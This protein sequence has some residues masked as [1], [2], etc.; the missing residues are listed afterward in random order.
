M[1]WFSPS[2]RNTA[3][4]SRR[5]TGRD[6]RLL[7]VGPLPPPVHGQSAVMT[8][9]VSALSPSFPR[10]RLV[11]TCDSGADKWLGA[12][13]TVQ[14]SA[15]SW[16]LALRS[17]AVYVAVKAG[18][19]MWLTTITAAFARMSGARLLLHHHSYEYVRARRT[20]MVVLAR[21]AGPD[22][23]HIV[24]SRKMALDLRRV[25]PETGRTVVLG[26]AG[27]ID[28]GLLEVPL[29]IPATPLTLGH[30]SNLSV[31]KGIVEVVDLAV[32]LRDAGVQVRLIIGGPS[33]DAESVR[34][35]DRAA[36][37]LG[38]L[39]EYR[40]LLTGE[41][42]RSFFHDITHFVFPSRYSHEA[43]PLVLYEALAAGKIC[44]ATRLGSVPEQLGG[45]PSVL[46]D[47]AESFV[48]QTSPIL[49]EQSDIPG[50]AA[51]ARDAYLRALNEFDNQFEQFRRLLE[52]LEAQ[53][54]QAGSGKGGI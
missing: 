27:M 39:F 33:G 38:E 13:V 5:G 45:S 24:L 52:G 28:S 32:A 31:D 3:V 20:R 23:D 15:A 53:D 4:R 18:H 7:M 48:A 17:D 51:Q 16:L 46:A 29:P 12:I 47:G 42:K 11:N 21:V 54:D 6:T 30:L 44:V 35:L 41:A 10:I 50:L 2:A 19:G 9:L 49:A 25:V 34:Q 8:N 36:R 40:G 14:R 43:V 26:N 37:A 22:A 1:S